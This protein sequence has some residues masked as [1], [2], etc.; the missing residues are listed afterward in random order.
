MPSR[1]DASKHGLDAE[2]FMALYERRAE[3]VLTYFARRTLDAQT[4]ADLT[5][6]TFA[7]AFV[8]RHGF[9]S[10]RGDVGAWLFG[11]ARHRLAGYLQTRSVERSARDRLGVPERALDDADLERVEAL[12]DFAD[13]GRRIQTALG[14]LSP[15]QRE[16]VVLRVIDELG[17]HEIS[18]RLG[19]NEDA[20]RARVSRGLRSLA[21]LVAPDADEPQGATS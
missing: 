14:T 4:A 3:A 19:I 12:I 21:V 8:S 15:E 7:E 18:E 5:A 2:A 11:I 10:R 1:T 6:E 13:V 20:V 16:A 9:D 17:Y